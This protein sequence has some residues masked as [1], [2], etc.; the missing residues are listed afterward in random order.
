MSDIQVATPS[1]NSGPSPRD[2]PSPGD[3]LSPNNERSALAVA[4]KES[5]KIRRAHLFAQKHHTDLLRGMNLQEQRYTATSNDVSCQLDLLTNSCSALPQIGCISSGNIP[6]Q[7]PELGAADHESG[8]HQVSDSTNSPKQE[9]R[10]TLVLL[11]RPSI[12]PNSIPVT[13]ESHLRVSTFRN[14]VIYVVGVYIFARS[15]MTESSPQNELKTQST[16]TMRTLGNLGPE[17]RLSSILQSACRKTLRATT[18]AP[19]R[20]DTFRYQRAR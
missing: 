9:L 8:T 13:K 2:R 12:L 10:A 16:L 3:A 17:H 5:L 11:L 18:S 7:R 1:S 15:A 20:L 4:A 6:L 14:Q 19:S